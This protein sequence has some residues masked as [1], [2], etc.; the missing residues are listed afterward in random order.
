MLKF[1]STLTLDMDASSIG[2]AEADVIADTIEDLTGLPEG[3]VTV[4][5]DSPASMRRRRL[6]ARDVLFFVNVVLAPFEDPD[7]FYTQT[8]TAL[9]TSVTNGDFTA[10]LRTKATEQS[11]PT[12][13]TAS[14]TSIEV[15]DYE[16]EILDPLPTPG[17]APGPSP[18]AEQGGALQGTTLIMV[19]AICIGIPV[20]VVIASVSYVNCCQPQ[21]KHPLV[22]VRSQQRYQPRAPSP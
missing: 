1:S 21:S 9:E 8:K 16:V 15:D 6:A 3:S 22:S 7:A 2:Q 18:G 5:I 13:E 4:P 17:P 19:V 14:A 11:V 12:L 10:T 20:L